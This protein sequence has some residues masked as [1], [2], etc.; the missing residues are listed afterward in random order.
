MYFSIGK[1]EDD[2]NTPYYAMYHIDSEGAITEL[3][4]RLA[5]GNDFRTQPG[6][7][8]TLDAVVERAER[9]VLA[10]AIEAYGSSRKIAAVLG[11]SQPTVLRKCK[12]YGLSLKD[13]Q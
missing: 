8:E 13:S 4:V 9:A 1:T 5:I 6:K 2:G 10:D 12:K 11:V 7:I 3:D